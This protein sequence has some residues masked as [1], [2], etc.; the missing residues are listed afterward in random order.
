MCWLCE[1]RPKG[2]KIT[3][4]N[5]L[6]VAPREDNHEIQ[7]NVVFLNA[8]VNRKLGGDKKGFIYID[9]SD[10][11]GPRMKGS[12]GIHLKVDGTSCLARHIRDGVI[13]ILNKQ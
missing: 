9:N 12:D 1:A 10:I 8:A 3:D 2:N 6:Q 7:R 11:R 5:I 4:I 13:T